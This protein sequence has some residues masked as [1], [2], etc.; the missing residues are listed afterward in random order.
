MPV[1]RADG[2]RFFLPIIYAAVLAASLTVLHLLSLLS[3]NLRRLVMVFGLIHYPGWD[4]PPRDGK[5]GSAF[6]CFSQN[7]CLGKHHLEYTSCSRKSKPP[8]CSSRCSGEELGIWLAVNVSTCFDYREIRVRQ[9]LP[10]KRST[11]DSS[12]LS[13]PQAPRR[14]RATVGAHPTP[15]RIGSDSTRTQGEEPRLPVPKPP[16]RPSPSP[17]ETMHDVAFI[18]VVVR[19]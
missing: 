7:A 17:V 9:V 2:C 16:R 13:R 18:S 4:N 8:Y 5:K 11:P 15:E 12:S 1:S 6:Y 3:L 14:S 19:D 10:E